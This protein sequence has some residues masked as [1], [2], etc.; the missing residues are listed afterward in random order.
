LQVA[1][2]EQDIILRVIMVVVVAVV[3]LMETMVITQMAAHKQVVVV[4]GVTDHKQDMVFTEDTLEQM[5]T[6]VVAVEDT[7]VE[8]VDHITQVITMAAVA[9]QD[10]Y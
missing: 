8:Q 2:V 3:E 4:T 10:I 7:M 9:V 5:E 6:Q 1:V